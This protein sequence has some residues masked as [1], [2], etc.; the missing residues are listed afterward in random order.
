M[1]RAIQFLLVLVK[2][3]KREYIYKTMGKSVQE[4]KLKKIHIIKDVQYFITNENEKL[5]KFKY[6]LSMKLFYEGY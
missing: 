1:T 4:A 3:I 6:N 5:I 2:K